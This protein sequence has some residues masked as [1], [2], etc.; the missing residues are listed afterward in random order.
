[1]AYNLCCIL[2]DGKD[3]FKTVTQK[4]FKGLKPLYDVYRHNFKV[5]NRIIRYCA[6]KKW[7]LRISSSLMPLSTLPSYSID[8]ESNEF[9]A[10]I[11]ACRDL[12]AQLGVRVSMH[13]G[14]YCVLESEN[15]ATVSAAIHELNWHG[16][17][18]DKLGAPRSHQ[19]PIN[20]HIYTS[21]GDMMTLAGRFLKG[22]LRLDE[23]VKS[24]LTVEN[25][26]KGGLWNCDN[27]LIFNRLANDILRINIPLCF[28]TLHDQCLPSSLSSRECFDAF[29]GTWNGVKPIFHYSE[30]SD[31]TN[32][33]ADYP[34]KL[35]PDWGNVDWDIEL[36]A[37]NH[38]IEKFSQF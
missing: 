10:E 17:L 16:W 1:M 22:F 27:L 7:G 4:H 5:L 23:S 2:N 26:D 31:G 6:S 30:S 12:I 33:H 11:N 15:E 20:T 37:K 29:Y 32:A 34:T 24:R 28:D 18:L 21:K 38:A 13:P 19:S 8:W 3:G 36:K 9:S 14:P 35:P 25:N